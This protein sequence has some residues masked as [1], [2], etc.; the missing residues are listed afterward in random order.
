MKL[1]FAALVAAILSSP[2]NAFMTAN[3]ISAAPRLAGTS[4]NLEPSALTEYMAKAHEEKI[5]AMKDIEARKNA[6]I[7]ALKSEMEQIKQQGSPGALVAPPSGDIANLS[8][9]EMAQKLI[10]YQQFMAKYIVEAQ[11]QKAKAV[12]AAEAAVKQKYEEK[13]KLLSGSAAE[14]PKPAKLEQASPDT[15]LYTERSEKVSA[16]AKAGKSRWGDMENERAAK[17]AGATLPSLES[18]PQAPAKQIT[19]NGSSAPPLSDRSLYDKR[20]AQVAA[21][22]KAGKSRWGEMEVERAASTAAALPASAPAAP[23]VSSAPKASASIQVAPEV[24]AADHGLR[25]DGGVGG[26]SLAE[27]I[28][29]GAQLLGGSSSAT[30]AAPVAAA[31]EATS[32]VSLFDKRNMMVA[33]AAK[34]G[35]SRWGEMEIQKAQSAAATLPEASASSPVLS[36]PGPAAVPPE[37]A[38]ADHGL[39]ND[40]G[41]GGPSL[42]ERINLGAALLGK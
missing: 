20:T 33:A 34:A 37:V 32:S 16:A 13:L 3:G 10:A 2:T 24:A 25:N 42:A 27:R 11:N 35:K 40:G 17:A 30:P 15:K 1:T 14:A 39:R 7:K 28:N 22:A 29:L 41:V 19:V 23:K 6:E 12:L 4:L 36:T 21:A 31:P 38:E 9:D 8:K 26:P 18:T 5:K